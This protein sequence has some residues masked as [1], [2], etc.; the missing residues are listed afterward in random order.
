M[1]HSLEHALFDSLK[2]LPYLFLTYLLLELLEHKAGAKLQTAVQKAGR[3]G[4][5]AGAVLGL[6]PQCGFCIVAVE[7]LRGGVISFG[8]LVAIMISTSDEALPVL[9]AGGLSVTEIA[10]LLGGKAM[11]AAAAGFAADAVCSIKGRQKGSHHDLHRHCHHHACHENLFK[12]TLIHTAKSYGLI[13]SA[14]FLLHFMVE[15]IGEDVL[16]AALAG[17]GVLVNL[18]AMLFGFLPGCAPSILLSQLYIGGA[19]GFGGLMAGLITN[20]GLGMLTLLRSPKMG[21]EKIAVFLILLG[22]GAVFALF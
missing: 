8:T 2:L 12:T 11:V 16:M 3:F 5:L 7:F 21:R 19:L 10:I 15:S 9:L 1:L 22:L 14:M 18:G 6:V 20:S 17:R 13:F 4:P